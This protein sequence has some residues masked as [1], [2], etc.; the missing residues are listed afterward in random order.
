MDRIRRPLIARVAGALVAA[1]TLVGMGAGSAAA[2]HSY[3]AAYDATNPVTVTGTIQELSYTNP[4]I[5]VYL[6]V[7]GTEDGEVPAWVYVLDMPAPSR[8]QNMGLTPEV[9]QVGTPLT[10]V[11]WPSRANNVELAPSQITFD[12]SG[13]TVRIR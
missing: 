13:Q 4:H 3:G 9:L 12:D 7:P 6:E 1:A 5:L 11:A 10:V 2:H 8:A